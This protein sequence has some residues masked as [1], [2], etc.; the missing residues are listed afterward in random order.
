MRI[1]CPDVGTNALGRA[2]LLGELAACSGHDVAVLGAL[3]GDGDVWSPA[4]SSDIDVRPLRIRR[5][6]DYPMA[7]RWLASQLRGARVVVSKP[8]VTSLGLTLAAGVSRRSL[9]LDTDDWE[10]GMKRT[11]GPRGTRARVREF[12][13]PR[14][15]NSYASTHGL[16][17][18]VRAFPHRLVSSTWL[19]RRFGGRVLPHVRDTEWLDPRKYDRGAS[20]AQLGLRAEGFWVGFVGTPRAHKG[21]DELVTAVRQAGPPTSLFMAG[22]DPRDP[23]AGRLLSTAARALGDRLVTAP[24]FPFSALPE[25]LAACDAVALPNRDDPSAWGQVPAKLFD[26]MAMAKPIVATNVGET[27]R[28]LGSGDGI[29]VPPGDVGA[30][31]DAM[32]TL[33]TDRTAAERIGQRARSRAERDFSIGRG[34]SILSRALA[35]VAPSPGGC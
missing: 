12:L 28:I 29:V 11:H 5:R 27:G 6:A 15:H 33:A 19:A 31:A 25:T 7:V 8:L 16:D 26:A 35:E 30:L 34:A 22:A 13:N 17:R 1:V 14:A 21:L 20:R 10:L 3:L 9:L 2:Q 23:Y 4:R 18:A 32:H 24:T